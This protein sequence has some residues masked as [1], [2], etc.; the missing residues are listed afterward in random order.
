MYIRL[1]F[2]ILF[3]TAFVPVKAQDELP[4]QV[5]VAHRMEAELSEMGG[6]LSIFGRDEIDL[7]G[8]LFVADILRWSPGVSLTRTGGPGQ[9]TKMYIRGTEPRHTLLL[10]DGMEIRNTNSPDGFDI[11]NLPT[12][13]IER[14]ELIRGPH[15]PLYGADALGGVLNI[16]TRD[17]G[18]K[19]GGSSEVSM[20]SYGT[21]SGALHAYGREQKL[22]YS[23][24]GS[25][26]NT[27]GFSVVEEGSELDP[28]ENQ[29]VSLSMGYDLSKSL[30]LKFNA[31]LIEAET[32]YD[33]A[34]SLDAIGYISE[35]QNMA[36]MLAMTRQ[37][38]LGAPLDRFAISHKE[39]QQDTMDFGFSHYFSQARKAEWQ[40]TINFGEQTRL[41]VGLDYL[42]EEGLQQTAWSQILEKLRSTSG[43]VQVRKS[44]G[45]SFAIDLGTRLDD[46]DNWGSEATWRAAASYRLSSSTRL[47]GSISTG[48]SPPNVYYLANAQDPKTLQPEENNSYDF[49]IEHTLFNG[50]AFL[51]LT[52]FRNNIDDLMGWNAAYKVINIDQAKTRGVE[53]S[54]NW[55][56]VDDWRIMLD[57]THLH[58]EDLA[59]GKQLDFRPENQLGVRIFW[60]PTDLNFS[61]FLGAR[62][63]S[64]LYNVFTDSAWNTFNNEEVN[65]SPGG[66]SWEAALQYKLSANAHLFLRGEDLFNQQLEEMRDYNGNPYAVSGRAF[67][68]G[69][70]WRF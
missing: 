68:L 57:W 8:G 60:Q 64:V 53:T 55:M 49:G 19:S 51:G 28:Y 56:P 52:Y 47:K 10:I 32:H 54:V 67:R 4:E 25:L 17:A 59:T 61:A 48:F 43:F 7:M 14:I 35:T 12:R 38:E 50:N 1:F 63:R 69:L 5:T 30:A 66:T 70:K 36:F 24:H 31:R 42:E 11:A 65:P 20:G 23:V 15:S 39:F 34:A 21:L 58:T 40:R 29:S 27:D 3:L 13:D 22:H 62:H 33:N 9:N 44:Y 41:M 16:V 18:G 37:I 26:F 45:E 6:S 2:Y 46:S